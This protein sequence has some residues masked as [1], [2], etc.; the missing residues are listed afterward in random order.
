[1][2]GELISDMS[3]EAYHSHPNTFSSSQLKTMLDDPEIFY[4]KYITK[5][6]E[7]ETSTAFDVGTYFHTA[8]LEPK[9]LKDE[10]AVYGGIRR[11]KEWDAFRV[12]NANKAIITES[13]LIQANSLINAVKNSSVAASYLTKS[14]PE[15]SCFAD[16]YV[17]LGRVYSN[18]NLL[19]NDG[20]ECNPR[21]FKQA[22]KKGLKITIKVRAD[23]L[24][25]DFILDLKST[26]GNVKN[27]FLIKSS[28]SKYSYDL[29]AAL[30]LDVFSIVT[31]KSYKNFIWTFASKDMGNCKSYIASES[32]IKIGRVKW[33]KAIV[34]LAKNI[35][36][37][38]KVEDTL[39]ILEPN[40]YEREYLTEKEEIDL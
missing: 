9:K 40:F 13:E 3:R 16:L 33:S 18:D 10:C 20:W 6:M 29:S 36:N 32:N 8:I 4:K 37:E 24:G 21:E 28:I 38:W 31:G 2:S 25:E 15:I 39:S 17:Y 7:K 19:S 35:I 14:E 34:L 5:E 22:I 12:K 27:E 26:S 1:M 11:G 23:A 30:Y